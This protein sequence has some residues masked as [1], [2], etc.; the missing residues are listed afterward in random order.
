MQTLKEILKLNECYFGAGHE[1]PFI[2][3]ARVFIILGVSTMSLVVIIHFC[4]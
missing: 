1:N 3:M 2:E 4:F